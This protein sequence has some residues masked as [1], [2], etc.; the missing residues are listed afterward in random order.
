MGFTEQKPRA[1]DFLMSEANGQRS[2]ENIVVI[3]VET[4]LYAGQ[5]LALRADGNYE[6]YKGPGDDEENP[7]KAAGVLYAGLPA[8]TELRQAVCI[9]RDAE[10]AKELLIG[11]DKPA[12]FELAALG[13]VGR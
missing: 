12:Q 8:S 2:R 6:P 11:L 5:L 9:K 7:V 13:I 10:V 1:A 3:G 4:D